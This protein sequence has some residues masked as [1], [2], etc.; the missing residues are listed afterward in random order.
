[1][2]QKLAFY[3]EYVNKNESWP[4]SPLPHRLLFTWCKAGGHY[5]VTAGFN[6]PV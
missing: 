4:F 1:M 5:F 2:W 6:P 3:A